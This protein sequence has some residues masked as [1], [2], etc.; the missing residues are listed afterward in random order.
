MKT[1]FLKTIK[2][3]MLLNI[4]II[5]GI[6]K[7]TALNKG[8]LEVICGPT[9]AG[10]T[11]ELIKRLNNFQNANI[12]TICFNYN[13]N[14]NSKEN[15]KNNI[16]SRNGNSFE[17]VAVKEDI[18]SIINLS[19]NACVVGIDEVQFFSVEIVGI[20][21]TLINKGKKVIVSGLDLNFRLIPFSHMPLLMAI[22]DNIIKLHAT[23]VRCGKEACFGQRLINQQPANFNTPD[24]IGP[25]SKTETYEP[26]CRDCF[27]ID[28]H[29]NLTTIAKEY[30]QVNRKVR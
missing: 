8:S 9:C 2:Y 28:H 5:F 20:I 11:T 12:P 30:D 18:N 24:P 7:L 1:N 15:Y 13:L 21:E 3:L 14:V 23:C 29:I 10:K 22:A 25:L 19:S 26:R 4:L 16:T 17:S 27:E 6:E